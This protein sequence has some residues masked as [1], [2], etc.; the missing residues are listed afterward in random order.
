MA[1]QLSEP[2]KSSRSFRGWLILVFVAVVVVAAV[3]GWI[4]Y[5]RDRET[6]DDAQVDGHIVPVAA[7]IS[8]NI[9]DLLVKDNEQV[10][11]G[12]VIAR[13]DARDYQ[14]RVDQAKAALA[15]AESRVSPSNI[16]VPLTRE[17]T[18][19]MASGSEAQLAAAEA[20][21]ARVKLSYELA[22]TS[23]LAAA[24]AVVESRQAANDRAQA[25]LARMRPLAAKAEISKQQLDAYEG[26]ARMAAADLKA[27]QEKLASAAKDA[28]IRKAAIQTAQAQVERAQAEV[29]LSKANFRKLDISTADVVSAKAAVAQAKT[30]LEAADL[31]LSYTTIVA[32]EEGVVTRRTVE[33]GQV[34]QPGQSL[35]MIVPLHK[36]WVTANFKETQMDKMRAGQRVE[37]SVDMYDKTFIGKVDSIAGATG[38]RLSLLPPENASGNFVKVVQRIPVKIVLD[39]NPENEVLRPGMN[40]GATVI[41]K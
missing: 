18:R 2:T 3:F 21:L 8:G 34:V 11:A 40:V 17:T 19:S 14:V 39:Q 10:K 1:T 6:T 12:Q 27:A 20:E 38:S 9:V 15:L 23:D 36:I 4:A 22:S 32:S 16:G 28:E 31:Q 5:N 30:N 7:K 29:E 25:D 37:I 26:M 35:L 24:R 13:I 33:V 41:T